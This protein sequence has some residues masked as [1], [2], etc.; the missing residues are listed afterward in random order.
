[1]ENLGLYI[2]V[3]NHKIISCPEID[4]IEITNLGYIIDDDYCK[5]TSN[6]GLVSD[7]YYKGG[8]GIKISICL[9]KKS[10]LIFLRQ[11]RFYKNEMD[12]FEAHIN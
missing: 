6:N 8:V 11:G 9:N 5:D 2:D 7:M 12:I 3:E 4:G 10:F 1:M